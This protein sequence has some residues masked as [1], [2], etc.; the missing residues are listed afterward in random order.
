MTGGHEH[1]HTDLVAAAAVAQSTITVTESKRLVTKHTASSKSSQN[2]ATGTSVSA[3][4]P[5]LATT[6]TGTTQGV[7][8]GGGPGN[9]QEASQFGT[10]LLQRPKRKR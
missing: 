9:Q 7:L 4:A 6:L 1:E 3:D 2:F 10:F 5:I 8:C